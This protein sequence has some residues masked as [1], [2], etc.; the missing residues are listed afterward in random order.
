[1]SHGWSIS[2]AIDRAS[3]Q[4]GPIGLLDMGDNVGGGSPGDGTLIAHEVARRGG[5]ATLVCLWDRDIAERAHHVGIGAPFIDWSVGGKHDGL[6]GAPLV[7]SGAVRALTDGTFRETQTTHGGKTHYDMGSTA[8]LESTCGLTIVA[9]SMRTPPFSIGQI[10][11]CGL[12]P[13]DY[14]CIVLKGVQAPIAAYRRAC[15]DFLRINTPGITTADVRQLD[16]QRR[17]NPVFPLE[18]ATFS[19]QWVDGAPCRR[20]GTGSTA[21]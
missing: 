18:P 9:H 15:R 2:E 16:Y 1:M 21:E 6:H 4:A 14:Q 10:T 12:S 11:S 17:R 13:A 7:I 5:P 3:T 19:P 20:D 8:V